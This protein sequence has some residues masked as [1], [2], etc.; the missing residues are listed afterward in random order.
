MRVVLLGD[1]HLARVQRELHQVGTN[2]H[3]AAEGGATALDL[4]AQAAGAAVDE[5]DLV[6][7][8]VGTNDIA[9]SKHVP[10]TS[11]GR[12]VRGCLQSVHARGWVYVAPP[13]VDET[14]LTGSGDRTNAVLDAYRDAAVSTFDD[15]GARVV[16]TDRVI[17]PLGAAAFVGDG[18]HLSGP[19]YR[20]VLPAIAAAVQATLQAS[21]TSVTQ[22]VGR[23]HRAVE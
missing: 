11:F 20:L 2:V 21:A 6:V 16:R 14:R 15:A 12:A 10:L 4:L 23:S 8:S 22:Q 17:S 9:P 18:L 19:A 1:S 13:G 5:S 7:V 3:N